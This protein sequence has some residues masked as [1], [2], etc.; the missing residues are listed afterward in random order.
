[1]AKKRTNGHRARAGASRFLGSCSIRV[2]RGKVL[3]V[4]AIGKK[5]HLEPADFEKLARWYTGNE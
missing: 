5:V 4:T 1:M 3:I 2:L